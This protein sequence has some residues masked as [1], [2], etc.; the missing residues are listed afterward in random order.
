VPLAHRVDEPTRKPFVRP[1]VDL[2][3]TRDV[4]GG[5]AK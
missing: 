3:S 2:A 5:D 1:I 4:A